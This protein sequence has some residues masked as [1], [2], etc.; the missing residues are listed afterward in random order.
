M[1]VAPKTYSGDF[2]TPPPA[3]APLFSDRNWVIWKWVSKNQK[4]TKP[5]FCVANPECHAA[6]NR[7]ETW[8][9]HSTAVSAVLAGKANGIGFVLTDTR[10][11]AVDLDK[12]CDPETGTID[13]WAQSIVGRA[14]NAYVEITVSGTGLRVIG[15]AI[16]P[17][18][19]RKFAVSNAR[20]GAAVEVYRKATRFITVSGMQIGDCAELTNID[21]LIDYIVAQ[22][23]GK[24]THTNGAHSAHNGNVFDN[25]DDLIK[26]GAP[27]GQRSQNFIR[28]VWSLLG[29]GLSQEEIEQELRRYPN[30]I[31]AKYLNPDRLTQEIERC[32]AKRR[33]LQSSAAA[34]APPLGW[35]DPD[36]SILEDRRGELPD[37]PLDVFS[38]DWQIWATNAAQGAGTT[39]DHV[40]VPLLGVASSLVGTARRVRASKSWSEPRTLWVGIVG[41]SGTGKTPGLDVTK[42]TL[43]QRARPS[44]AE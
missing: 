16:G 43:T 28:V 31:A 44:N 42:R 15:V 2:A 12:C 35:D 27:I 22:H 39:V 21:A 32:V 33:Q 10:Y 8:G 7:P 24:Q 4:W 13:A 34:P 25:I 3:L 29:Q 9:M 11:A 38:E 14:P 30:G 1:N 20:E 17:Q 18:T 5:P 37:F 40:L 41:L 19:H 23:D 36:T 26:N 6:N